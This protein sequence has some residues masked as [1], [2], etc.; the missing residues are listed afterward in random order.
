MKPKKFHN[1]L[2]LREVTIAD[3]SEREKDMVKGGFSYD[4]PGLMDLAH[5]NY[6][7]QCISPGNGAASYQRP[8]DVS[9]SLLMIHNVVASERG[10]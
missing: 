2:S 4:P 8:L 7:L 1:K 10:L 5:T 3:L 9:N 6:G